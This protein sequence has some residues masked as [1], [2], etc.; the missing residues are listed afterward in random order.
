[1]IS[2]NLKT[3]ENN[4]ILYDISDLKKGN[5]KR[6]I[7]HVKSFLNGKENGKEIIISFDL[8]NKDIILQNII[9]SGKTYNI[10]IK[11]SSESI[12]QLQDF[13]N[14]EEAFKKFTK[15]AYEIRN[16]N[17]DKNQFKKFCQ[18][19]E[20][21]LRGRI[22]RPT[23]LLASYHLAF[24]QN[25]CNFSVPGAGKT[26]IVYGAYCYL[27][28]L[29]KDELKNVDKLLIIGPLSCFG[30]WKKEYIECFNKEPSVKVLSGGVAKDDKLNYLYSKSHCEVTLISYQAVP[31]IINDLIYF[32]KTNK[33]MIVLD[34]AHKIK[35]TNVDAGIIAKSI[36]NLAKYAKSRVVL[37]GTPAPNGYEDLY[38]LYNF[39]WPN[40]KIIK[41]RVN[42]LKNMSK[43]IK[44]PRVEDFIQSIEPFFIRIK[45]E[46]LEIPE[47]INNP[48]ILVDMDDLQREIYTS[49][50][51]KYIKA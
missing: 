13:I 42:Q 21:N 20:D 25:A 43:N 26:S 5:E 50:E 2:I 22:L 49:I 38:N 18:V 14:N 4:F 28:S 31:G 47:P 36:L 11:L 23:Q 1:M 12:K 32:L 19:L 35:N 17:C 30:P 51:N 9:Q 40:K 16:N 27:K 34:E 45:K 8:Q 48:P 41:Y 3:I 6:F 7:R 10:D 37:T 39:I 15:N 44:D 24:S 46:D 33:V 29:T